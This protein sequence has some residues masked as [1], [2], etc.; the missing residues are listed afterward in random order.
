[1]AKV[2]VYVGDYS[3]GPRGVDAP[4]RAGSLAHWVR[5]CMKMFP[6][7]GKHCVGSWMIVASNVSESRIYMRVRFANQAFASFEIVRGV[8]ALA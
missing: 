5:P 3:W 6:E 8:H 2:T 4:K 1:M 7:L